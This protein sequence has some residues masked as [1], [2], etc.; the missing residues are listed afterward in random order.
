MRDALQRSGDNAAVGDRTARYLKAV[1]AIEHAIVAKGANADTG[2]TPV[3]EQPGNQGP[4][5]FSRS[6][7]YE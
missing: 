7:C 1:M 5:D 2:E 4:A 6:P 3:L